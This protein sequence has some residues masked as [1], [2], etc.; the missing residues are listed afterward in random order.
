MSVLFNNGQQQGIGG[1]TG[2]LVFENSIAQRVTDRIKNALAMMFDEVN[3]SPNISVDWMERTREIMEFANPAGDASQGFISEEVFRSVL[4]IVGDE[5]GLGEPGVYRQDFPGGAPAYPDGDGTD[6]S[7]RMQE[8][9]YARSILHNWMRTT[10]QN[11]HPGRWISEESSVHVNALR[12]HWHS[13]AELITRGLLEE[14]EAAWLTFQEE[15]GIRAIRYLGDTTDY[16]NAVSMATG[17]ATGNISLMVYDLNLFID[18]PPEP[19]LPLT[20]IVLL[21]LLFVFIAL[22]AFGLIRR[23]QPQLAGLEEMEPELSVE[24]FLV[25]SQYEEE[26]EAEIIR[27]QEIKHSTE[28]PVKEQIDKF[29]SEEPESVAHLLRNWIN[30]DWD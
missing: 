9:E 25:S 15:T 24:D 2:A 17:I 3:A 5:G 26:K 19:P 6:S 11:V 22:L 21:S 1:Q 28:S 29:T 4:G 7:I 30:E 8:E 14:G 20:T 10:E 18:M 23:A 27:L 13:Q 16:V 12:Y